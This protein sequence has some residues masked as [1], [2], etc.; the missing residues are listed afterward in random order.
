MARMDHDPDSGATSFSILLGDAPHLDGKYTIVGV[1]THGWEVL[2][3]FQQ[4]P[5]N[6]STPV[7][8]LTVLEAKLLRPGEPLPTLEIG[9]NNPHAYATRPASA[10]P[11]RAY[12]TPFKASDVSPTLVKVN[13]PASGPT[14]DAVASVAA[15]VMMGVDA[16]AIATV[17]VSVPGA[18]RS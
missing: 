16:S 4:V 2:D 18:P 11:V 3:L 9:K 5:R 15:I 7:E 12:V 6:G 8:R 1:M 14:S 17:A 13:V 10:V